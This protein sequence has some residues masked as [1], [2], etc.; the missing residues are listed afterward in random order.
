MRNLIKHLLPARLEYVLKK[1]WALA[2]KGR[3]LV[4]RVIRLSLN[5]VRRLMRLARHLLKRALGRIFFVPAQLLIICKNIFI[6]D[7]PLS[8]LGRDYI[9]V[10]QKLESDTNTQAV[11]SVGADFQQARSRTAFIISYTGISNEPRV[12]RQASS[13]SAAGWKVVIF[14]HQGNSEN[15]TDCLFVRV[16]V[17]DPYLPVFRKW[18]LICRSNFGGLGRYIPFLTDVAASADFGFHYTG[19]VIVAEGKKLAAIYGC[20]LILCHDYFTS[21]PA[22]SLHRKLGAPTCLDSHEYATQQMMHSRR[23]RIIQRPIIQTVQRRRFPQLDGLTTVSDGIC[24]L[25]NKE[26]KLKRKCITVRS[27]PQKR[28]IAY[29]D[30]GDRIRVLYQGNVDYIRGLHK[31]I[32]SMPLWPENVDLIIRGYPQPGYIDDLKSLVA[33]LGLTHR[34]HFADT[35]RFT[36]LIETAN[37]ADIGYYVHKDVSP[38]KHFVLPNKFFEYIQAGLALCV[39]DLPSMA[40]IVRQYSLGVLV[41]DYSEEAIADAI[42]S[43]TKEKI[44]EFKRASIKAREELCWE[45]ESKKLMSFYESIVE[46]RAT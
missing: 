34:V 32:K 12:L 30:V 39:N 4:R 24:D 3:N 11:I 46:G 5:L 15:P 8:H 17:T 25:L 14:G 38:Q 18:L 9:F 13:L 21:R 26:Y 36:E 27:I 35:V 33:N 42:N 19:S 45:N 2:K 40:K 20:D 23:W 10:D 28:D 41:E 31:A 43:L 29:R 6:S 7:R 22:L 44:R 1:L 16:P 37:E